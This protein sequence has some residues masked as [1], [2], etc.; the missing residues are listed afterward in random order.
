MK[1]IELI[2]KRKRN[3]KHFLQEDG[4]IVAKIYGDDVHYL[5]NGKYE[6]IDNT[7]VEDGDSYTNKSNDYKIHFEKKSKN[8]LMNL[9]KESHYLNIKL[10]EANE[11]QISKR[12]GISKLMEEVSY[13]NIYD[14]ID[15][16]YKTLP[17]KVKETI[18]LH[19]KPVDNMIFTVDTNLTL[20]LEKGYILAKENNNTIFT[21]EKPY[22]EDSNGIRNDNIY[23]EI[24][25]NNGKYEIEL[26][27]DKEWLN[28][29]DT[30]YP[31]Y[32]DPT[33]SNN[34]QNGNVYDTYIYPG[35]T[36][37]D[38]NSQAILKAGVEKVNGTNRIN[39]ALIKF[40]LPE[41]GTGSEIVNASL[42]LIGYPAVTGNNFEQIVEIHRVIE[43]WKEETATWDQM[44]NKYDEKVESVQFAKRST[45][46]DNQIDPYS[47]YYNDLTNLVKKW[48]RDTPNYGILIKSAYEDDYV[49][50]N[51][52][53]FFSKNNSVQGE[54]PKPVLTITYRNQNGL[55]S[56][57]NYS[58]QSFTDGSTYM[59]TYNGNLVGQF[60]IGKTIGGKLPVSLNLIYNTNDVIVKQDGFKFNLIQTIRSIT[61]ENNEYLEYEDEDGTIHY[62]YKDNE[63]D[64]PLFHD[65]DGLSLTVVK[66][67][68]NYIMSDKYGNKKLFLQKENNYYLTQFEDVS[69]N[70][71]QIQLDSNNR[72]SK[73]IDANNAEITITY[74]NNTIVVTS[75]DSTTTLNY[76]SK[77]I[78]SIET[79]NGITNFS[80]NDQNLIS[81]ITDVN[82]LKISYEYC[83]ELPY[84]MK[85]ITQYGLNGTLGGSFTVDYGFDSTTI[86]D[87]KGRVN[88]LIF[89]S[90]GGL[91]SSNNMNSI[92][93]IDS[94]YSTTSEHGDY[95]TL[96]NKKLYDVI[97]I[98]YVKNYLENSSFETDVDIFEVSASGEITK[99]FSTDCSVSG[100]RSLKVTTTGNTTYMR[101][102]EITLKTGKYYTFSGYF[103]ND[104]KI[105][106][107]LVGTDYL[108]DPHHMAIEV[109]TEEEVE[110][111]NEFSRHDVTFYH[112]GGYTDTIKINIT[113]EGTGTC[114]IDDIQLEEG[115]VANNYNILEN[116][117]FSEGYSDWDVQVSKRD[118]S[119]L[120]EDGP[121][122]VDVPANEVLEVVKINNN[123][124]TALKINMN[125]LQ[126]CK[127]KKTFPIKGKK[128]EICDISFWIKCDGIVGNTNGDMQPTPLSQVGNYV[129]IAFKPVGFDYGSC[130]FG[131]SDFLPNEK[132]QYFT[133]KYRAEED[134]DEV[135]LIFNNF[136]Q[137]NAMYITNLSFYKQL[138]TK[139]YSY[140]NQG[141]MT[142]ICD[143]TMDRN[144]TF[145][146]D[147]NNQLIEST[148]PKGKNF[149]YEYDNIKT[150]R[151]LSAISAMGISNQVKYDT[152]GNPIL[153]RTSKKG[154]SELDNGKY[155]IRN[156]GTDTYL[157]AEYNT[158][159]V[160]SDS[161]S[162]TI[163]DLQKIEEEEVIEIVDELDQSITTDT[164]IHQYF[165]LI[166]SMRS[167]YNIQYLNDIILLTTE[168]SNNLFI[169]KEVGNGSYYIKLKNE[170]KYLRVN[171]GILEITEFIKDDPTLEFYFEVADSRFIEN[172]ATYTEDGRFVTSVTD[173]L[174]HTTSYETDPITGLVTSMTDANNQTTNYTYNTKQQV[175]SISKGNKKITYSYNDQNLLSKINQGTKQ[176]KLTYDDFLKTKKVMIGDNIILVT[177]EY[178]ENNGNL[179]KSTYGNNQEISFEYDE[180]DRVQ[181]I[182]KMD[183][184]YFYRYDSN[185]NLARILSN[186]II[187]TYDSDPVEIK[188]YDHT[189]KYYYDQAKRVNEYINDNFR[190]S[191]D[192]DINSNVTN[193]KYSLDTENHVLENIFDKD[194]NLVKSILDNQEMN[195]E[196]DELGRLQNR[197]INGQYHT[198]YDYVSNGKRTST[199]INSITNG[200]NQYSYKYDDLN[201]ITHIYYNNEL[202]NKYYYDEYNELIKEEDYQNNVKIEY[203]YDNLGNLLTKNK[204]NLDTGVI[205]KTDTYEYSNG[206]WK[207]QLIGYNENNITYDEIGNPL[208]IGNSITMEWINGKSLCNYSD[209]SKNLDVSYQYNENGIRTSKVVNGVET[210]YYLENSNIVY[211][212]RGNDE[213]Y[214]LYNLTGLIGLK[215]NNDTYYYVK[216]L[217]DDI[218]GILDSSY[219]QIVSYEYD[220]W[221]KILSVKDQE[222]NE[223]VNP[224]NIGIIN[225][226]RYRSYYYDNETGFY[227]LNS[228]YYNPEWC[229][230]INADSI[231]GANWD[232]FGYNLYAYVSNNPVN[233]SDTSGRF[234][235]K[236]WNAFKNF[237]KAAKKVV[238][239]TLSKLVSVE[240]THTYTKSTKKGTILLNSET[241]TTVSTTT[242]RIGSSNSPIKLKVN[243]NDNN[244]L[245]STVGVGAEG[246]KIKA[247]VS[248]GLATQELEVGIKTS[249]INTSSFKI[250]TNLFDAYCGFSS[251]EQ[252]DEN[253]STTQFT[254][255]NMNKIIPVAIYLIGPAVASAFKLGISALSSMAPLALATAQK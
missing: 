190:I 95:G 39:R 219:N 102:N 213:L 214:Y 158:V 99:E 230:F 75:P 159:L 194:D 84:R 144:A 90:K 237:A 7:L 252:I 40:D 142:N 177:N 80:Y 93:E 108:P 37:V 203:N 193:K 155:K 76:L 199:L 52:P 195:Y 254:Q 126:S 180:F 109:Q 79:N 215:Y 20:E 192:Y 56:Y 217:Q 143:I 249:D 38:K 229:R 16:E 120:T 27:L 150:D 147:K 130:E 50:D 197:N 81:S 227:Y 64:S 221:G 82:G 137:A 112:K 146:Y 121:N 154:T 71:V 69:G 31:V 8:S 26:V 34:S 225:P 172:S 220:S 74:D 135:M 251:T 189:I 18:V 209:N 115:E 46:T 210:K 185:G 182:H 123:Q 58:T 110:I 11:I 114:Y 132:W 134:F 73:V 15:I 183:K 255:F 1:Q 60:L 162:N 3:E 171:N 247:D 32:I 14:G 242:S 240:V 211:E 160:E 96:P 218:I 122:L 201:N 138:N 30:V 145:N 6:E 43:D 125:P 173:S 241:G 94:A 153:T 233:N 179:L 186:D 44:N 59:N 156:K 205:I 202:I 212:K 167:N 141:N 216:N 198:S 204:T 207:D 244:L 5:K 236:A 226:F 168:N 128:G 45:V 62:F 10:K 149:N 161:C 83:S 235:K 70:K 232:I 65:E 89:N 238:Q 49:N 54:N 184:D 231:I 188:N 25:Q 21:I 223:I 136:C 165:K 92:E 187:S 85:K 36:G 169:I 157:K 239:D 176:F 129:L 23:Y 175:T 222:G 67:N 127:L 19:H 29:N 131:S 148:N 140:D 103:K 97:P 181:T 51:Y 105:K 191:Y 42:H 68:N 48:Y 245:D 13:D 234:F 66:E 77:N 117:D 24:K 53:A 12:K 88:T 57:L 55:E 9:E 28:S 17:T 41:I 243:I 196:Y 104:Q 174:F 78:T 206:D 163:W 47:S 107:A 208:T 164:L 178:G 4:T 200:N 124:N 2:N 22:M 118:Y 152:F 253:V 113:F 224:T 170:E 63:S 61:L 98:K 133:H 91:S 166:Y 116:S 151:V 100:N 86:I 139:F 228:R 111:S 35:D 119:N 250:G 101:S 33:I 87:H 72:I 246:T 106:I 248:W